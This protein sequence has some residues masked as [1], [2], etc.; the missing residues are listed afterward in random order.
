MAVELLCLCVAFPHLK[1]NGHFFWV[2]VS[3]GWSCVVFSVHINIFILNFPCPL[4]TRNVRQQN[5]GEKPHPT[6]NRIKK[7]YLFT[8]VVLLLVPNLI[9]MVRTFTLFGIA[10]WFSGHLKKRLKVSWLIDPT[11]SHPILPDC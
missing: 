6:H 4:P 2:S 7:R 5:S 3:P 9:Q 1:T 8:D 10:V 11:A